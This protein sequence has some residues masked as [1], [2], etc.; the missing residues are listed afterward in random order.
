MKT[1]T[2]GTSGL[3]VS[4]LDLGYMGMSAAH[5]GASRPPLAASN[6]S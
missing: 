2:L 4:A 5:G 6:P 1:R 3:E